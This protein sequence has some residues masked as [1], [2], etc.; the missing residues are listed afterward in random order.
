M[1]K[2]HYIFIFAI[3]IASCRPTKELKN[4][5]KPIFKSITEASYSAKRDGEIS[6]DAA[7]KNKINHITI[8]D[9]KGNLIE[10][11]AFETDGSLYEKTI[12]SRNKKGKLLKGIKSNAEGKLKQY[13]TT[14]FDKKGNIIKIKTEYT[15]DTHGNW[16]TKK[17]NANGKLGHVWERTI[18]YHD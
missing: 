6:R 15:Y 17:R 11:F 3:T 14:E 16:I 1:I 13:W 18:E 4:T 7:L 2:S 12:L 9:K 5:S 8:Y 10:Q